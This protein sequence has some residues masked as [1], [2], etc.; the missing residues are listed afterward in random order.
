MDRVKRLLSSGRVRA[1][2][3]NVSSPDT[4]TQPTFEL[5]PPRPRF[6]ARPPRILIIGAGSRGGACARAVISCSNGLVAAVAEP[7][8]FRRKNFG[9]KYIWG[10]TPPEEGMQFVGWEQFIEWETER[11]ERVNRGEAG[12]PDGV[13][14]VIICTLDK[15]HREIIERL[16]PLSLHILCEKPLATTLDDCIHIYASLLPD[17]PTA[18]FAIGTVLCHTPRNVLLRKLIWEENA[19]GDIVSV[20][21]TEEV[22]WWHFAHSYVRYCFFPF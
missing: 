21:H 5:P 22:G 14:A 6:S 12:V 16:V 17:Q 9:M 4:R 1:S 20:Q 3:S 15:T 19:I 7:D 13:D 11:R 18:L 8:E 10:V 2:E